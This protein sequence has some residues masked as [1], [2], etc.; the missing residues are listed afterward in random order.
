M[1]SLLGM[2][3][4]GIFFKNVPRVSIIGHAIDSKTS[5]MLRNIA[6][7][8]I[9]CR[10]GLSLDL[11]KLKSMKLKITLY[12]FIP[13]LTEA[14]L[15]GIA[16][17]LILKIPIG[18]SIL[19][20]FVV[21]GVSPAVVV[22]LMIN[23]QEKDFGVAKNI[24]GLIIAASCIDNI[25]AITGHSLMI[26]IVF[27][28]GELWWSILQCPIQI[29]VGLIFGLVIGFCFNIIRL[30]H[31]IKR[32]TQRFIVLFFVALIATIGSKKINFTTSG[33][34]AVLTLTIV[35]KIIW[36]KVDEFKYRNELKENRSLIN[37]KVCQNQRLIDQ[38]F[39][40]LWQFIFLPLLFSL[41][42]NEVDFT[43]INPKRLGLQLGLLCIGLVI[44]MISTFLSVFFDKNLNIKEKMFMCIAWVPK[45]TVQA[46]VGSIALD[47]AIA[48]K[49]PTEIPLDILNIAVLSII[50]TAPLGTLLISLS[51]PKLLKNEQLDPRSSA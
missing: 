21:S 24:P 30:D 43:K 22:P 34:L 40:K 17:M 42:G 18:W 51:G 9:L 38:M 36:Q 20:G 6:F 4:V 11:V 39:S 23:L 10:A 47:L 2:L 3:L 7:C 35:S 26:G 29:G 31:K 25:I 12:A 46:A 1:P 28:K 8:V 13:C 48:N 19:M 5:A 15:F 44:R 16:A 14:I 32:V 33:P 27:N 45:A 49:Y 41:I 37:E 50:V